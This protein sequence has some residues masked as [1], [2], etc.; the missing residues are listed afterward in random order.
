MQGW[1]DRKKQ[2]SINQAF[3]NAPPS[4]ALKNEIGVIYACIQLLG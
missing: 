3:K 2:P 4:A 1:M